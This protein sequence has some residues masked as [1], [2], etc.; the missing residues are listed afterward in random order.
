MNSCRAVEKV[1][2]RF[3]RLEE[4]QNGWVMLLW[5]P[6]LQIC[7]RSRLASGLRKSRNESRCTTA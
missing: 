7:D 6:R 1:T 3:S 5:I 2:D 4:R